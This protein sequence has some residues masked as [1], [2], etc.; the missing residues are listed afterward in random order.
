MSDLLGPML[1]LSPY[2]GTQA[3]AAAQALQYSRLGAVAAIAGPPAW[4]WQAP[5]PR[6]EPGIHWTRT[7]DRSWRV[8][9]VR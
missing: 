9:I 6:L 7:G 3:Q 4:W 2:Q 8:L 5:Q 1:G